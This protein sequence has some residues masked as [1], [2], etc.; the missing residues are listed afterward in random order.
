MPSA[1]VSDVQERAQPAPTSAFDAHGPRADVAERSRAGDRRGTFTSARLTLGRGLVGMWIMPQTRRVLSLYE[2]FFAGGARIL[3][4][5][6]VTSL[7]QRGQQHS[8]L[9]LTDEARR[10]GTVQRAEDDLRYQQLVASGVSITALDRTAGAEP[11]SAFTADELRTAAAAVAGAD[12]ILTLKEQ[13]LAL[14]LELQRARLMPEIPVIACLHRSDPEHSGP[15]LEWLRDATSTGLVTGVIACA[16][17]TKDAYVDAGVIARTS[18]VIPNGIDTTR[19]QPPS[20]RTRRRRRA[21]IGIR[22]GGPVILLAARFDAMKDPELFL[23][24]A[25]AHMAANRV[26]N[27]VLCGAG[28]TWD[29]PAFAE[30]A[31][32]VGIADRSRV[33]ALGIRDDMPAIY[34][35]ADIVAL[36]SAFG[37]ASPLC[38]IEGIASGAIPVTTDVG[39]AAREVAGVGLVT[40]PDPAGVAAAWDQ[41]WEERRARRQAAIAARTRVDRRRMIDDYERFAGVVAS[42]T[43]PVLVPQG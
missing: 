4:T 9:S 40:G 37:E 43:A 10:E 38:L 28:M 15:A 19:F 41:A 18:A 2:G 35:A 3:H 36:T 8:V 25:S 29:N 20:A 16:Q 5:D 31:D 1:P 23:R 12:L 33:H 6:V 27:Y 39:D 22:G 30:L 17:S 34:Q 24:A 11:P 26:S 7:H 32:R 42:Q 13:P 14:L 21:A